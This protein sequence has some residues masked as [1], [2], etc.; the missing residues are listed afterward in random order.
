[1]PAGQMW[2]WS[3]DDEKWV[4]LQLDPD[5]SIHVVGYVDKLSDIGDVIVAGIAEG[6][7]IY[8]DAANSL[9]KVKQFLPL[10]GGTLTG[11]LTIGAGG[12]RIILPTDAALQLGVAE[13]A[14]LISSYLAAYP[15]EVWIKPKTGNYIGELGLRPSGTEDESAL[16][17]C[18]AEDDDNMG[19]FWLSLN[20]HTIWLLHGVHGAGVDPDIWNIDIPINMYTHPIGNLPA[21]T[22][23][24]EAARKVYVDD[25][26]T[27]AKRYVATIT[28]IIDGGGAEITDGEKGHLRIPFA[29]TINRVT[30]LADQSGSI[31]VDIWKDTYTNFPPTV[32]DT[33]IDGTKPTITTAQKSEDSTLTGWDT[34]IAADDILAFNVDSCTDIERVTIALKVTKT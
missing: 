20:G 5:G 30:M 2:G 9:W 19:H 21:P 25:E 17:L 26:I 14:P 28:F 10:A 12:L 13:G 8:W 6:M 11:N 29:C 34:A 15:Y 3:P 33:I 27:A 31:V 1:M 18:N 23:D 32:A 24:T 16:E 4:K 22:E 7:G